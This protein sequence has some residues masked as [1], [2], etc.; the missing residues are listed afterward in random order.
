MQTEFILA[1]ASKSTLGGFVVCRMFDSTNY[2]I[3]LQ[4]CTVVHYSSYYASKFH[5]NST[6][7]LLNFLFSDVTNVARRVIFHIIF[8]PVDVT[9][10]AVIYRI[11][12]K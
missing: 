11:R 2:Q 3:E 9:Q 7:C 12:L 1:L 6:T 5:E 4:V 8:S 10:F